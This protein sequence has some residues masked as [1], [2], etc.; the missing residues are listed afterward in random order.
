MG[1]D[2]RDCKSHSE[3]WH[4][5][6]D[7]IQSWNFIAVVVLERRNVFVSNGMSWRSDERRNL[8][9]NRVCA[10]MKNE[11]FRNS[12]TTKLRWARRNGCEWCRNTKSRWSGWKTGLFKQLL[13]CFEFCFHLCLKLV[14]L[15]FFSLTLN[16]MSQK[17]ML[18]ERL[19]RRRQE[20]MRKLEKTQAKE[21]KV[22]KKHCFVI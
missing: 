13:S 14:K 5:S 7:Y 1:C 11:L 19:S 17:R 21:N 22:C 12:S 4:L 10:N 18:E 8:L 15:F 9:S 3:F 20:Q 16:K 2:S 6:T